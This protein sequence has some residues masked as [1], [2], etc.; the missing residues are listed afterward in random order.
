MQGYR[1]SIDFFIH[2]LGYGFLSCKS[3]K[4][5]KSLE[6]FGSQIFQIQRMVWIF[7][8]IF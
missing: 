6:T 3:K 5:G 4:F 8:W 2:A 1:F 7:L